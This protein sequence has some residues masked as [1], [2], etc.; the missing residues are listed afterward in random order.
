MDHPRFERIQGPGES[1]HLA[2]QGGRMVELVLHLVD[3]W[4]VKPAQEQLVPIAPPPADT[5]RCSGV[6][7]NLCSSHA[8]MTPE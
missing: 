1:L 5:N 3:C 2:C 4:L 8:Q 7:L 6:L